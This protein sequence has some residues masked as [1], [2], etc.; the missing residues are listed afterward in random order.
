MRSLK[1][2]PSRSKKGCLGQ[3]CS[4]KRFSRSTATVLLEP[5][6]RRMV[7]LVLDSRML[8]TD[9]TSVKLLDPREVKAKTARF[10]P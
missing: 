5:L 6:Y 8:H 9:D 10:Q 1:S 2:S 3:A 7:K 4:P